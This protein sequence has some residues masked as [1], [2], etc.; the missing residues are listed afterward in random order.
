LDNYYNYY[1]NPTVY[2]DGGY[3]VILGNKSKDEFESKIQESLSRDTE[4]IDIIIEASFDVKSSIISITTTLINHGNTNYN[5]NLKVYLT[6]I[7]STKW[8]DYNGN[9]F[10]F[11]FLDFAQDESIIIPADDQII[12]LKDI[13][14]SEND[15][16]PENLMIF[17]VIFNNEKHLGYSN[18]PSG[19]PF[20]AY[21][22]DAVN[23]TD[24]VEERNLPPKVG[25]IH[26]KRG[27][28][29]LF[30]KEFL[31]S[32]TLENTILFGKTTVSVQA[33]D[34]ESNISKVEFYLDDLLIKEFSEEPYEWEWK[35]PA[36]FRFKHSFN[37]VA[38]DEE[39]K[40]STST[41]NVIAFIFF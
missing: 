18:P 23:V 12:I 11:A 6:E 19:N 3:K 35:N 26:P 28:L 37:V 22:I 29:H 39:G 31:V 41:M 32:L 33:S 7:I 16:D 21:Y 38:Y 34:E 40:S 36:M 17:A 10:H 4:N 9:P 14:A 1:A 5:G 25:I 27:K 20:D 2:I 30:G 13:N 8:Q 24:V 15:L